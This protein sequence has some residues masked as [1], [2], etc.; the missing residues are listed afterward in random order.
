MGSIPGSTLLNHHKGN[1]GQQNHRM[2][3]E[4]EFRYQCLYSFLVRSLFVA[5]SSRLPNELL[6]RSS[7]G[8]RRE[9]YWILKLAF[10]ACKRAEGLVD[11]N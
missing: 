6:E 11:A 9:S 1:T 3:S 10:N 5:Q 4:I 8:Q 2:N 7:Y